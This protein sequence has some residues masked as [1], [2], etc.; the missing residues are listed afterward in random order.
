M[1]KSAFLF[2][3][4]FLF[5]LSTRS[6]ATGCLRGMSSRIKQRLVDTLSTYW[7]CNMEFDLHAVAIRW[8]DYQG[9]VLPILHLKYV[10][11]IH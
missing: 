11:L 8:I 1:E 5:A 6:D 3:T 7:Q 10:S 2:A 4:K 9:F